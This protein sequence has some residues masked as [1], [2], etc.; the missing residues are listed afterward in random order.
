MRHAHGVVCGTPER[1]A[2]GSTRPLDNLPLYPPNPP[3]EML[4]GPLRLL[5][6]LAGRHQTPTG[7]VQWSMDSSVAVHS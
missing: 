2:V 4:L 6:P 7:D 5:V 1:L 3:Y